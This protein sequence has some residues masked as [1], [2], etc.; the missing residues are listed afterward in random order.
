MTIIHHH[1]I[2]QGSPEWHELRRGI[3]TASTASVLITPT[4]K[5]ADNDSV[6][7]LAYQLAAERLTGRIEKTFVSYEMERG[8]TEEV[9]A[10]ELY[11]SKY[12][13]VTE[14]GFIESSSF[15]FRVGYSPDG[16]VGDD[17]LIEI[18]S[19]QAKYQVQTICTQAVPSEY[20]LQLQF[21]LLVSNRKWID[22]VQYSNGMAMYRHRV[23]PNL[24]MFSLIDKA[25]IDFEARVVAAI[26]DYKLKSEGLHVAEY[27]QHVDGSE[28]EVSND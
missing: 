11:S 15:G 16:L 23:M 5:I 9:F 18:K 1:N 4:G 21:G 10:R 24:E 27:I 12:V 20:M 28:I 7:K 25:V 8:H 26:N 17:G 6:R 3:I 22:F 14:C 19:R 13:P 2:I